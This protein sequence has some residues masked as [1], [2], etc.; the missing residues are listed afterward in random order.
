MHHT[1]FGKYLSL[2]TALNELDAVLS[3]RTPLYLLLRRNDSLTAITYVPYLAKEDQRSFFLEHRHDLVQRLEKE[4][5]SQSLICKEIGE[6]TDARS[7][8]ERDD[9]D[10]SNTASGITKNTKKCN[11]ESCEG[12][13]VE[14]L[15]YKR[16][17][18]RLCDRRMKNKITP[19]AQDALKTLV[20]PGAV[21]QLHVDTGT[22]ILTLDFA[23][24]VSSAD[25]AALIPTA[26]P[27]FTFFHH[28]THS[29]VYFIFHSP[30]SVPVQQR[31]K[32][33][34]AIPGLLVHAEDVGISV[35]QKI[36]IHEPEELEFVEKDER[37]G[38]FRSMFVRKGFKGTELQYEGAERDR[39]FVDSVR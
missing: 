9:N 27:T 33:T 15:G 23:K 11:D 7:W 35:D 34:M 30:D 39:E 17:K 5:F 14:D 36:E 24:L 28:P 12:C 3:P 10:A 8:Q 21:V 13:A 29:L 19:E 26:S 25:I 20:N 4:H 31:M 32:H 2:K 16:N 38:K 22:E 1:S 18:C 6:I 37:I